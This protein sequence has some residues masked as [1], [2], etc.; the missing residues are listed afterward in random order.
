MWVMLKR[1]FLRLRDTLFNLISAQGHFN[2]LSKFEFFELNIWWAFIRGECLFQGFP[3]NAPL[4]FESYFPKY[5][6]KHTSKILLTLSHSKERKK[7]EGSCNQISIEVPEKRHWKKSWTHLIIN[8]FKK[9]IFSKKW[10]ILTDCIFL[11]CH[12]R[13]LEWIYTL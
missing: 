6:A 4:T 7:I 3:W 1:L 12:V 8:I 2:S 11:S 9:S 10:F 13:V 5:K